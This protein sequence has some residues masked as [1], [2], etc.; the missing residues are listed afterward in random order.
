MKIVL[1]SPAFTVEI[2]IP[3][4]L[5]D[6]IDFYCFTFFKVG[7]RACHFEY[8]VI[9]TSRQMKSLHSGF[10]NH[11]TTVVD[12]CI[13]TQHFRR[14]LRIA[15]YFRI[16]FI[17]LSLNLSCSHHSLSD[18]FTMLSRLMLREFI[19]RQR[20]NLNLQIYAIEQ[21]S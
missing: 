19:E 11:H 6:M 7:Y 12:L 3:D 8:S 17:P 10:Q 20:Q 2:T 4:C 1:S 5:G 21:R 13:L 18:V 15:I 14:H 9:G 16:V